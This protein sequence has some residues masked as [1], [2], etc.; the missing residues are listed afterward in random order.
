MI[1]SSTLK[2]ISLD[3]DKEDVVVYI[4]ERCPRCERLKRSLESD[5]VHY[6]EVDMTTPAALAELRANGVFTTS[7][8]V[9]KIGERFLTSKELF[10]EKRG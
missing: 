1:S 8:P 5:G 3:K 9:L 7:A 2:S 6:K 10:G 4:T